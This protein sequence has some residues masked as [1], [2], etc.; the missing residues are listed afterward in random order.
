M[1]SWTE[2]ETIHTDLQRRTVAFNQVF[3]E[4]F[5]T[6]CALDAGLHLFDLAVRQF[7]PSWP[8]R[9]GISQSVQ[10]NFDFAQREPHFPCE[11]DEEHA[12][13]CIT[14]IVALTASAIG[15]RKKT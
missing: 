10:E 5:Q 9:L 12:V 14:G 2:I 7:F 1:Q 13:V 6:A 8:N 3:Q 15:H 11:S 4:R